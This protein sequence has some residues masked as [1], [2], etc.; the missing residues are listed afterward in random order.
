MVRPKKNIKIKGIPE[1]GTYRRGLRQSSEKS[2]G[3]QEDQPGPAP[4]PYYG[5]VC[6]QIQQQAD[7]FQ[8]GSGKEAATQY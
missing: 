6:Q 4:H 5:E 8:G 2:R 7:C 1:G 3:L